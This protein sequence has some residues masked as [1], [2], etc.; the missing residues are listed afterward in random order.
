VT[1]GDG[2]PFKAGDPRAAELGRLGGKVTAEARRTKAAADPFTR[3]LLGELLTYSTTDWMT[4][5]GLVGESWE[6]WRIIG[7]ALDG[8]PLSDAELAV[9]RHLTART[10]VPTDLRELWCLAG[11]GSGKTSF[12]ALQAVKAACRGYLGVRGVSRVLLLAFVLEQSGIA[13]DYV[14]EFFDRD[15]ELRRLIVG[16]TRTELTL[17]HGVRL[18]TISANYRVI[19]GYSVACALL[20][21]VAHWWSELTNANPDVEVIRA[22]R[23]GLGKV[24]GSRL[25]AATTRWTQ[26]GQVWEVHQ[27]HHGNEASQHILVVDAPTLTLNPSFDAA[28]IAIAEAEDAESALS[29]YGTSWRT[30]GGTLVLSS[31]YDACVDTGVTARAPEPPLGDDYYIAAVDLS[32]G[33]GQDSAALSIQHVEQED[34]GPEVCLQDLLHEWEPVFDPGVLCGEIA[35]ECRRFG[36]TEVV[37]DQFSE[38]FAASEFRRHRIRYIVSPRKTAECVLDSIA[39]LNTRRVRLLDHPKLRSQWLGLRRDYASGGRPTILET[40]RHDDLAVATARGIAAALGL[41]VEEKPVR[42]LAFR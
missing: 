25:L 18:Q 38:G 40:R 32:G 39:V 14:S 7:K 6:R 37:G 35:A 30:A 4:R 21:E 27:R 8:L 23:P 9:Y 36:I 31:A 29:E 28:T 11:R 17:G 2:P 34:G 5:L 1:T 33:T 12:M 19:R 42:K 41:G 26:E 22:L 3:G 20:D 15:R 24:P 10:T 13:F 16:R